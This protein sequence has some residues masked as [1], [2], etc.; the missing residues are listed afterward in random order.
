MIIT[1][2][3]IVFWS[4]VTPLT[5]P[6]APLNSSKIRNPGFLIR[7]PGFLIFDEFSGALGSVRGVT[8]LQKTIGVV[9]MIIDFTPDETRMSRTCLW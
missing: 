8:T 3:P 6:K 7:N 5:L 2:T 1:T 4:V 9:V